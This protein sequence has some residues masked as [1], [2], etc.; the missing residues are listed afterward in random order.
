MYRYTRRK[1]HFR[2][3]QEWFRLSRDKV[4]SR[5]LPFPGSLSTW[6]CNNGL[7]KERVS[8]SR[9]GLKVW[10][11]SGHKKGTRIR[12]TVILFLWMKKP[13]KKGA[14]RRRRIPVAKSRFL[15]PIHEMRKKPVAKV[16]RIEQGWRRHKSFDYIACFLQSV[17][18]QPDYHRWDHTKETGRDEKRMAVTKGSGSLS[19]YEKKSPIQLI[20]GG[21]EKAPRPQSKRIHPRVEI[22]GDRSAIT[23]PGSSRLIPVSTTPMMLVQV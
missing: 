1:D 10:R 7:L 11:C 19:G 22:W 9:T 20:K 4:M 15:V 5:S 14:V 16:P 13:P 18:C 21:M 8:L 3:E 6:G 2:S 17:E 23:P 12:K